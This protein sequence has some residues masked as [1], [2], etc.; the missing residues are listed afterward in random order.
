MKKKVVLAYSGGLD[1]SVILKWLIDKGYDVIAYVA[2]VG[3]KEDYEAVRKK[4][5]ECGASKVYVEDLK[6]EFITDFVFKAL[7]S[8][9]V[10]EGRYLLGTSIARPVIAKRHIDVA[11][12]EK[13][14]I[15]SHGA[16]G[17]GNDQVRFELTYIT[18]MPEVEIIAPWKDEEFLSKFQGRKDML[19]YAEEHGIP[20]EATTKKPYSSDENIM[21]KSYEAGVLEDPL[22]PADESM[23][24]MTVS[25]KDAPDEKTKVSVTFKAGVPVK[26][27]SNGTV[28]SKPVEM[29]QFLNKI[30]G[31]NGV[32]RIDIVENRFVGMKS[33][34]VY[35]TPG[36][37][38]LRAAHMDLEGL[39]VDREVI[40]L[41][42]MLTPK[43]SEL[44][45]YGFWYAPEMYF[46]MAAVEES[47]KHV[48]G[49]VHLSLYKGNVIVEGRE[50]E[51]SL[52][53]EDVASMDVHG[54]YDQK[55][56]TGFIKLN[57]LRLRIW[58]RKH[59][60]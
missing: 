4:A 27:E 53:D 5:L 22:K 18:L 2:D 26:V 33:R 39:T 23:F 36:Y 60:K 44:M 50:S 15:V 56:A 42:D 24:T 45:Y 52:Y 7:K 41:R 10:Y 34:G 9:A 59:G 21:H 25:P 32:G 31:E 43:I 16:T 46:L 57:A 48:S 28:K 17:K 6:K 12:K 35:E 55:D 13:T 14:N 19:E 1:T 3:Q 20:V 29:L 8:N 40:H 51:D 38:V 11:R 47:Q 58:A 49:T 30:A 54:G 37:T